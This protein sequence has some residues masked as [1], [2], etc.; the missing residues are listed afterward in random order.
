[1]KYHTYAG[2]GAFVIAVGCG[3]GVGAATNTDSPPDWS[4]VWALPDSEFVAAMGHIA[5]GNGP[6]A[7]TYVPGY[8]AS[9]GAFG[10]GPGGPPGAGSPAQSQANAA[11]CLPN[12]V[13]AV[14]GVPVGYEF[15][16]TRGLLTILIEEGPTIRQVHLDGRSHT[17]DAD[18]SYTGESIG[19]WE[20]TT[21]VVDTTAILPKAQFFF[22]VST[23]GKTHLIERIHLV[24]QQHLRIDTEIND[25][26][27]LQKPWHYSWTYVRTQSEFMANI[28]DK[29]TDRDRNGEP[30]LTPPADAGRPRTNP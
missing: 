26:I 21:L 3:A 9:H 15:L 13:P 12:G 25:P 29:D 27:A 14:M 4:G 1:M 24:D 11:S 16:L 22:G 20:G 6:E 7:A 8:L 17:P 5:H 28:C 19:H 10:G 18:P 2:I 23:S 30:D